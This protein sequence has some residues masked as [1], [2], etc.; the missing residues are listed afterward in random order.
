MHLLYDASY[1]R[2]SVDR[3]YSS[4]TELNC[5]Q[6]VTRYRGNKFGR[7]ND[8]TVGPNDEIIIID[9]GNHCIVVL[10]WGF[11]LLKVI[12]QEGNNKRLIKPVGV[13]V[14]DNILAVSDQGSHQVKKYSLQGE[15][16][17]VIGCCGVEDGQFRNPIGGWPSVVINSCML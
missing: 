5:S 1:H 14:T 3:D 17:S 16:L 9:Y 7:L 13:A 12:G 10:D 4:I 6:T 2:I 15:F 8:V 11:N